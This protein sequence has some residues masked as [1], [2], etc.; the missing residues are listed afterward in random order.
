[1]TEATRRQGA[2]LQFHLSTEVLGYA[3]FALQAATSM[4]CLGTEPLMAHRGAV[5]VMPW[6][7]ARCKAVERITQKTQ[8]LRLQ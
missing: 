7:H 1:M 3:N 8:T 4:P 6:A 5:R 2:A